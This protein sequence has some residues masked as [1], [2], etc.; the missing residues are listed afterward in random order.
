MSSK[1]EEYQTRTESVGRFQIEIKSYRL[2]ERYIC[3]VNNVD[4][5]ANVARATGET[6]EAAESAAVE[7][8]RARVGKT[9]TH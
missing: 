7:K 8:A 3:T 6:R 2:G 9:R 5:G 4:P 1:P